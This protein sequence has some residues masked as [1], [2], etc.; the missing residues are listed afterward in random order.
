ME[1]HELIGNIRKVELLSEK[2]TQQK[3]AG[4]FS[5]AF[6]GRGWELDHLRKY[7]VGDNVKDIEWNVTARFRETHVKTFTQE[8]ERLV[9]LLLDVSR[10]V[11]HAAPGRSKHDVALELAAALAFSA[12]E[13]QDRVGLICYS[14]KIERWVPAARGKVHF[15][16]LAQELVA[17]QPAGRATSTAAALALWLNSNPRRS[18]VFLISDFVG[19]DYGRASQLLAQQHEL[20]AIRVFDEREAQGPRLGW[21]RLQDAESGKTRWVNT[22]S[23]RFGQRQR[24]QYDQVAQDFEAVYSRSAVRH[25]AVGTGGQH[26]EALIGFLQRGR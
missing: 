18:V 3:L 8:K 19:E 4:L 23:A 2:L 13:S 21:L 22:S 16:R 9:W 26:L 17:V 11:T 25:L 14:D 15:W 7:E 6:K 20:V 5:S 10:S 12:L 1:L 24:Q